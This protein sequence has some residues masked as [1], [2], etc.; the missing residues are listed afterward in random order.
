MNP[1][2]NQA[3]QRIIEWLEWY[4]DGIRYG[5]ISR[6]F[7]IR[8]LVE[9]KLAE[10]RILYKKQKFSQKQINSIRK[11]KIEID[12]SLNQPVQQRPIPHHKK[13]MIVNTSTSS[14]DSF[15]VTRNRFAWNTPTAVYSATTDDNHF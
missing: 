13:G 4:A 5:K 6:D 15:F 10:L 14:T 1:E 3:A 8:T 11:L 12:N 2:Y 9:S 7:D